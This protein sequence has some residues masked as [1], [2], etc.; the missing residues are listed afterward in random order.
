[1]KNT[2]EII[3]K[4]LEQTVQPDWISVDMTT[5]RGHD[6]L[7]L[8]KLS[9][10][11]YAFDIQ[12]EAIESAKERTADYDNITYIL[13]DHQ[14]VNQYVKPYVNLVMFNLGYLPGGNKKIMTNKDST[15]VSLS[16][17]HQLLKI[18]SYLIIT[19]YPGHRGGDKEAQAV[20]LWVKHQVDKKQYEVE[21]HHYQSKNAPIAYIMKRINM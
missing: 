8:G 9:K 19:A 10:H 2:N 13:D 16:K 17:V 21:V 14:N 6:T 20:E 11:V 5:G 4:F 3:H 7:A 18:N 15:L 12:S 1:M